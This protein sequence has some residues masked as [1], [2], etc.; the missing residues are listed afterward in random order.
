MTLVDDTGSSPSHEDLCVT[1]T[2]VQYGMVECQTKAQAITTPIK[3]GVRDLGGDGDRFY[4]YDGASASLVM[5]STFDDATQPK[6]TAPPSGG[7]M[8]SANSLMFKQQ[9]F[10]AFPMCDGWYAGLIAD[11]CLNMGWSDH[12]SLSW[13]SGLPRLATPEA[14]E[15]V[16]KEYAD[17]AGFFA[18]KTMEHTAL[19]DAN[20]PKPG[21]NPLEII[22]ENGWLKTSGGNVY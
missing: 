21:A 1:A 4:S 12:Y 18:G 2:V 8:N 20:T 13:T 16:L 14:P 17:T 19:V 22:T 3:V 6:I 15:V 7:V 11:S 10:A 5:Y 9:G